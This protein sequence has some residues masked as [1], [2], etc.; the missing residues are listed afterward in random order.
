MELLIARNPD[1]ESSLPY[2]LRVPLGSGLVFRARDMAGTAE[3]ASASTADVRAWARANGID[4]SD[5]GRLR[6]YVIRAW[7]AAH[8]DGESWK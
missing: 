7:R 1:P 2:L 6:P 8:G 5:R 4:V 3:P